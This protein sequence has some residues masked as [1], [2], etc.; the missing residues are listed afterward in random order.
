[1]KKLEF[2][3]MMDM[4]KFMHNQQQAYW[5]Y[6][7]VRNDSVRNNFKSISNYFVPEFPNHIFET[8]QEELLGLSATKNGKEKDLDDD[9]N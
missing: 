9:S 4:M 1:M 2:S 5:K 6:A 8:W 3:I 7:K